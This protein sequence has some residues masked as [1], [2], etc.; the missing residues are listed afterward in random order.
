MGLVEVHVVGAEVRGDVDADIA[1]DVLFGPLLFRL[2][3]GQRPLTPEAADAI[4]DA[5]LQGLLPRPQEV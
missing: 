1:T 3:T 2:M 5:A 4:I